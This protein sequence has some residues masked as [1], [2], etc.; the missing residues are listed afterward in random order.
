MGPWPKRHEERQE[1]ET[2]EG[3]WVSKSREW[4]RMS[5]IHEARRI[6]G[7]W[8]KSWGK[9]GKERERDDGRKKKITTEDEGAD[10]RQQKRPAQK[11]KR[12]NGREKATEWGVKVEEENRASIRCFSTL[13]SPNTR[14]RGHLSDTLSSRANMS[15][16]NITAEDEKT[17]CGLVFKAHQLAFACLLRSQSL[18]IPSVIL[19][20]GG[21]L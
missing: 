10:E 4:E 2:W 9:Q 7:R 18:Y 13:F 6:G 3:R 21:Q 20:A 19:S 8:N 1:R 5:E 12:I 11:R 14:R 15:S 16:R 17:D